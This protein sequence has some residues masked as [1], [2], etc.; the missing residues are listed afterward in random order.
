M[1]R[2]LIL[3]IILLLNFKIVI[4]QDRNIKSGLSQTS[5]DKI[6]LNF[7][8]D[9]VKKLEPKLELFK[10]N[11]RSLLSFTPD[12]D[13][14]IGTKDAFNGITLKYVGNIMYFDTT[15]IA[16][17]GGIPDL[18]KTFHN[19]PVALG[20]ESNQ[21]FTFI[22]GVLEAG[23]I[24]WYQND[25]NLNKYVKQT[26]AGIFIQGGYK[27]QVRDTLLM[28]GGDA[29]ESSEQL[30]DAILRLKGVI[31][32]SPAFYFDEDKKF[33]ISVIGNAT[34]WYDIL[35]QKF[36]YKLA[37]KLRFILHKDLYFDFGYEKGSGAP[38]FNQGEQFTANIGF[39]F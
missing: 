5:L 1:K 4:S 36:Y 21:D 28:T 16:G 3:A 24:P 2:I 19:F 38:N 18:G 29:D 15:T 26:K 8:V 25:S 17:E 10:A 22:N 31:G 7:A 12:I 32:F 20:L 30:D 6:A 27:F 14:L 35:N 9:Y 37:G 39:Q 33:G 13:V 11:N 23:Y 34:T